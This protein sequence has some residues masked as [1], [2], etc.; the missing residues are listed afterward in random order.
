MIFRKLFGSRW[1][2]D[3]PR[4]YPLLDGPELCDFLGP[5]EYERIKQLQMVMVCPFYS[6]AHSESGK[7]DSLFGA[8][9]SRLLIRDLML[10][11]NISV[12]GPEDT[13]HM[14]ME[15]MEK[16]S[17]SESKTNTI[18]VTGECRV[19]DG[20]RFDY[21][22]WQQGERTA[23]GTIRDSDLHK[24]LHAC[25]ETIGNA[26][27]GDITTELDEPWSLARPKDEQSLARLGLLYLV[28]RREEGPKPN[29]IV[30]K[31]LADD[32]NFALLHTQ[33][34]DNASLAGHLKALELD[35][36][37]AQNCFSLF[38]STWKSNGDYEPEAVQFLRKAITLSPGHGKA[39]M[40]APH[41]AHPDRQA[42]MIRHSE[43]GYRLLPGNP[44]AINNYILNL[45]RAKAPADQI[46]P[47]A[48]EGIANDPS[49]PGNYQRMIEICVGSKEYK[50]ALIVAEELQKL[51]E[52]EM[53]ERA[54]YCLKQNPKAAQM[55][56]SGECDPAAENR[57]LIEDLKKR[58]EADA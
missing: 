56:E 28:Y 10:I 6:E 26:V 1:P 13:A 18:F 17:K 44:F 32:P 22:I 55:I 40:C 43:L 4:L 31:A 46:I 14:P 20:F 5:Q 2:K 19:T 57:K 21:A 36:F 23:E 52:P 25:A 47:L 3:I 9:L 39:H 27:G 7:L 48:K 34:K 58:A 35:P 49:D 53:D 54:L 50:T 45:Q 38:I 12:R 15:F 8:G 37:D 24:F 33:F 11:K 41:A 29:E 16:V 30:T 42:K 51:Y